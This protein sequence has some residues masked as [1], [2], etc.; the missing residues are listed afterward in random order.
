MVTGQL[1]ISNLEVFTRHTQLD[2]HY[3]MHRDVKVL[4]FFIRQGDI[5]LLGSLQRMI[6]ILSYPSGVRITDTFVL[7][8]ALC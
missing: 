4:E 7:F 6:S 3:F 2:S 5:R 8:S 1:Q